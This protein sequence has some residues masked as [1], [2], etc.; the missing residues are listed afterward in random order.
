MLSKLLIFILRLFFPIISIIVFLG[1]IIISLIKKIWAIISYPF[2]RLSNRLQ[3]WNDKK[4]YEQYGHEKYFF[5]SNINRRIIEKEIIP[6]LDRSFTVYFIDKGDVKAWEVQNFLLKSIAKQN[7]S[8]NSYPYLLKI[9]ED[10]YY[11]LSIKKQI[12]YLK[13]E[14]MTTFNFMRLINNFFID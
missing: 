14:R 2:R 5:Y 9:G 1:L 7:F 6:L 4:L 11:C 12:K 10:G 8:K 3:K 13:E